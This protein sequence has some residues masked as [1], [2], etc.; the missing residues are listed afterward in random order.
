LKVAFEIVFE[1]ACVRMELT[2]ATALEEAIR[3]WSVKK[4]LPTSDEEA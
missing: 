1:I 2:Q 4:G 3:N